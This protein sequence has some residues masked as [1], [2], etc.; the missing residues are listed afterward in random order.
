QKIVA[1]NANGVLDST[2]LG[3]SGDTV[4]QLPFNPNLVIDASQGKT[5]R[6]TLTAGVTILPPVNPTDGQEIHLEL[7][8]DAIGGRT[9]V[10]S[11][12]AFQFGVN[13]TSANFVL[14]TTAN[15]TDF[16]SFKYRANVAKWAVLGLMKGY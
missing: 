3:E 15:A 10:L 6:V 14:S 8:Q 4:V 11:P 7:T 13:L 5:F 16:T 12:I 2:L 9:C 1:T